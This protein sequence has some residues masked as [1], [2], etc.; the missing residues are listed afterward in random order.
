MADR[1]ELRVLVVSGDTLARG[2]LAMLLAAQPG[3]RVV[4]QAGPRDD[5]GASAGAVPAHAAVWDLG[6]GSKEG[7]D[8]I[9]SLE[10]AGVPV[11]VLLADERRAAEALATGAR[12]A[13]LR[14]A[15]GPRLA[16]ALRAVAR[17]LV[18][19]DESLAEAALR[20][21][22]AGPGS[23]LEPLTPREAEVLQL[24][25]QGLHNKA[26]AERLRISEHTAKFHVT[27][28]L[29]K[30][31]AESRTEAIVQAVR[32]GLVVL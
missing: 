20:P 30:L 12:G 9:A 11:V 7:L 28:I 23:L 14:E 17:G 3:V 29:G 18:V 32:L 15:D 19:L 5:L 27:A 24:L 21:R 1:Q 22:G 4:R 13:L 26:I 8:R 2:G 25:A 31:G 6:A 16:D 10:S